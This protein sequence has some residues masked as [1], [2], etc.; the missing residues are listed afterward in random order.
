MIQKIRAFRPHQNLFLIWFVLLVTL[1]VGGCDTI[2]ARPG[3]YGAE[4]MQ[5]KAKS[6]LDGPTQPKTSDH[7]QP[8]FVLET[9]DI[10]T[11]LPGAKQIFTEPVA[12]ESA[13]EAFTEKDE[14]VYRMG[15]G[16][17]FSYLI[18]GRE[19]ISQQSVTVSPDG[20]V[21]L[22]RIGLVK[23]EGMTLSEATAYVVASLK[24]NYENPEVTLLMRKYRNNRV[25]MLGQVSN[26]GV[27]DLPGS[28]TLLEALAMAGGVV[29]DTAGNSP[30]VDRAIIGRGKDKVIWLDL[31]ELLESGNIALN[32]RLK[33]GDVV[34]IPQGQSKV[35]YTL[36]QVKKPGPILLRTPTTIMDVIA[37]SGGLT[38][39][40][41][42]EKVYLVRKFGEKTAV[43]EIDTTVW[44]K[45]GDLRKNLYIKEGDLI[46]AAE[47][48]IS[49]F[50]YY[51]TRLLPSLTVVD[52]TQ[53]A[54]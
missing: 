31:Q 51:L 23:I 13:I 49:R 48:G 9:S 4:P 46:Y 14:S 17:E 26:P 6:V 52:F 28:A 18:R 20:M 35:A 16:D 39:D 24:K 27:V 53:A 45:N 7:K 11:G 5:P 3:V 25:F 37:R 33:N 34:F 32:A 42:P 43:H 40:A 1:L 15:P 41:D 50:N 21:A 2:R 22:P 12:S 30:P 54:P 38:P 44:I 8:E 29:K 10:E 19:D 47:R 36:G